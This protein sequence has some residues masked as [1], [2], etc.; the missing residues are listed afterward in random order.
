MKRK[1]LAN[2]REKD[3]EKLVKETESKRFEIIKAQAEIKASKEKNFKKVKLLRHELSQILTLIREKQIE[4]VEKN[5]LGK[6]D[7]K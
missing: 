4:E 1:E 7:E 6:E 3:L 5:K 2:F